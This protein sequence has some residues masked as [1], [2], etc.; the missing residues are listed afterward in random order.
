MSKT[1]RQYDSR[2]GKLSYPPG[3]SCTMAGSG[4]GATAC[5]SLIVNNPKY[6]SCTPKSTRKFMINNGHAIAGHGTAWSGIT[7]CLKHFG[8]TVKTFDSM[9]PF[10][11]EMAKPGRR[12][13]ILFGAGTRGGVTWTLGGHYVPASAYKVVN[14]K[15]YLYTRDPGG[16]CND[17]WHCYEDT[18]RGLIKKL[19]V[20]YLP[21][22]TTTSSS[23]VSYK[24]GNTY[25][26]QANLNVR[27]GPGTGY[28]KK[29]VNQLT[30]DGKKHATSTKP[31]A[32]AVLKK[33]TGVSALAIK[34]NS[35]NSSI[36][37]KIPSGY[38]CAKGK[39]KIYIK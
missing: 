9:T 21:T 33:G 36:W 17:G 7:A 23:N 26:L 29:K 3:S 28:A 12:C 18:M 30:A 27:T 37:L 38:V 13:V 35:S 32:N 5:A 4:C 20:C 6:A 1:F 24:A 39:T 31:T 11:E 25:T 22:T 14:G 8:F 15:H 19:W 2:W 10:F 16:R 34:N